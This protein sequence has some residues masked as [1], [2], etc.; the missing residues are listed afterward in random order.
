[1]A[2]KVII[3]RLGQTMTE[4]TVARW[5]KGDGER[6]QAGE[7]IYELEYDKSTANVQAKKTGILRHTANEGQTVPLGNAVGYIL[8]E[9][10]TLEAALAQKTYEVANSAKGGAYAAP[11]SDSPQKTEAS[12]KTSVLA[13]PLVKKLA[14]E[15]GIDLA[16]VTPSSPDGRLTKADI[17]RV[18]AERSTPKESSAAAEPPVEVK[19]S[20]M[21]KR[22][23]EELGVDLR[24]VMA[25]DGLRISKDDVLNFAAASKAPGESLMPRESRREPLRGLRKIIADRMAK[26]YF[27]FPTVTL[28]TDADMSAL[29]SFRTKFNEEHAS[30]GSKLTV[31][32]MIVA[33]VA[34]ALKE[35][36]IINASIVG[37][38]IVY[39]QDI[40][41][42]IA[43]ALKN[44]LIVPVVRNADRLSLTVLPVET[45]R[46]VSAAQAG[47]IAADDM[48]G[49]TF[50]VTNLGTMGI[51]SFNP[52]INYPES[53]ILGVGRTVEKPVVINGGIVIRPK[54]VLSLTHDHRLIDGTPAAEFLKAIVH[55]IETPQE[56]T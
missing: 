40:N 54:A 46:L 21:A 14:A 43:V 9:G 23:A 2:Q 3:P 39:Y 16:S 29:I 25:A 18:L 26:S 49:G 47:T 8:E 1:M 22:L 28:T 45:K 48:K 4:G 32:D 52:I 15:H 53:A 11:A 41:V 56:L 10:E 13:S 50:T 30:A 55:Y 37:E 6:V 42:G 20:P 27:T 51:D 7:D 19:A 38:E 5:L 44:G 17:E 31:T 33:A 36:E 12:E 35:F 34:K 24:L